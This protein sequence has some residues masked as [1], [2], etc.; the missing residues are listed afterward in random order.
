MS[1]KDNRS[2]LHVN[3]RVIE[4]TPDFEVE[5]IDSRDRLESSEP[6]GDRSDTRVKSTNI[7]YYY[8]SGWPYQWPCRPSG[9]FVVVGWG[10]GV[11]DTHRFTV[12]FCAER[13]WEVQ[14]EGWAAPVNLKAN[15]WG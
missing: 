15:L 4:V 9:L 5:W 7:F 1:S 2:E 13:R 11:L 6:H 8:S 3:R 10:G 14:G 12:A